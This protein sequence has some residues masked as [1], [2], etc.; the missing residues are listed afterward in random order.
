M[1]QTTAAPKKPSLAST[2][3]WNHQETAVSTVRQYISAF[4][5]DDSI[6]SSMIHMPTGTGK[7]GVI[8]CC[9]HFLKN[10]DCVL[11]LSPRIALR[12]QLARELNGRFFTKLG[13]SD[14]LPKTVHNVKDNF[15]AIDAANFGTTILTMTIQM[16]HSMRNREDQNYKLLQEKVSLLI[17]DE[18]HY[19]PAL[20]WREAIRAIPAPRVVFTATPFRNDLKLF[21]V[22]VQHSFS[23]TFKEAIGDRT[24]RDVRF[25]QRAVQ[26]TPQAFVQ[27]VVAFYDEQ[28]PDAQQHADPPRAIIRCDSHED[29][30]RIGHHE[31][32]LADQF[33]GVFV[34]GDGLLNVAFQSVDCQVH[35]G[36]ADGG[37]VLLQAVEG[38]P[39]DGALATLF[40]SASAL[41][42]HA[43]T[44]AGRSSTVP[45]CGSMTWA[46]S[47]TSETGV[48]NS[49]PSWAFWSAN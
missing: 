34:V 11:V 33:V 28:F 20:M 46:M 47:E 17:V 40:D 36:Q 1:A 27:D 21:D 38:E 9:S 45:P 30:R 37:G 2:P 42:E 43:A 41:H 24:I 8:A 3:L 49:P 23:Y 6:G 19:E 48:K 12:D 15:P 39:I 13:L 5:K 29:I 18:G 44:A 14:A 4:G 26:D 25:H 31:V 16:L 10:V 22:N 32:G 35:L 7:T